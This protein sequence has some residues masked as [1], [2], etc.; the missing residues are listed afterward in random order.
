MFVAIDVIEPQAGGD[1]SLEL[2]RNFIRDLPAHRRI[3]KY[4]DAGP[5][6]I[7]AKPTGPVDKIGQVRERR[8]REAVGQDD[9]QSHLERRQPPRPVDGVG[10]GG[11]PDHETGRRQ[12]AVA[13]SR[14][15]CRVDFGRKTKIVGRYDQRLQCATPRRSR[16]K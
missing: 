3:K 6:H 8:H 1:K 11:R 5:R 2:G 14:L 7:A 16:R 12:D 13:V 10:G 4:P 15:D 9:V